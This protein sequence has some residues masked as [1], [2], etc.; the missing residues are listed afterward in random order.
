MEFEWDPDK[1]ETNLRKHGID[2]VDAVMVFDDDRA[3][4]VE[5]EHSAQLEERFI[6]FGMDAYG[7]ILGVAHTVV[8]ANIRII[9]ARK[10]TR[11]ERAQYEDKRI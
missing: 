3:I 1:A 6:V 8:G 2:F 7:R 4:V 9:S 10:A 5:D 11:T